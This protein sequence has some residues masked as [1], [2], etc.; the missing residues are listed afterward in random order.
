MPQNPQ[1]LV[2]F[3]CHSPGGRVT[4]PILLF[5]ILFLGAGGEDHPDC[6]MGHPEEWVLIC[7]NPT[8][9]RRAG[10]G[11][12]WVPHTECIGMRPVYAQHPG[13]KVL[14]A[15]LERE[16]CREGS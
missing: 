10:L 16:G 14:K 6:A 2:P 1:A 11:F 3:L 13:L 15:G 8:T 4:P 5:W 12:L 7:A 9:V